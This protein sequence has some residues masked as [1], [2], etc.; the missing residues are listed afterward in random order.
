MIEKLISQSR[1]TEV[2]AASVRMITA[3]KTT[4]L[5]TD[6]HM[7]GIFTSLE[8]D[9][10]KLTKAINRSKAESQL[11]EK[12]ELRDNKLRALYYLLQGFSHHPDQAIQIAAVA[13]LTVFDK[14]GLAITNDSYA[15]ESSLVNSLLDELADPELEP[16]ITALSGCTELIADLQA[17]QED[18]ER[19]GAA[20]EAEKGKDG[21]LESASAIKKQIIRTIN[22]QLV[23]YLR[24]ML[25]VDETTYGD[26]SRTVAATIADS[27]EVV[28][29][30]RKKPEPAV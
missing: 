16:S 12:D 19:V 24:A 25:Q 7:A 20:Y 13:V 23:V 18:F 5:N 29:K 14:Y 30:R 10:T 1:T 26:F 8:S 21:T 2:A 4:V 28:K 27:N 3:F 15:T 17:A 6:S 22:D 9:T 11:E